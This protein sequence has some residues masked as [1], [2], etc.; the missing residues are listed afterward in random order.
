MKLDNI[1]NKLVIKQ[2]IELEQ[3]FH[4]MGIERTMCD[5]YL[6]LEYQ[7][8]RRTKMNV[9]YNVVNRVNREIETIN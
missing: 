2:L 1:D 6:E 3:L 9:I 5:L 4:F 8:S 7:V